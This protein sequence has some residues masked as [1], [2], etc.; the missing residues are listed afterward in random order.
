VADDLGDDVSEPIA[1]RDDPGAV[2]FGGFDM[3]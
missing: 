2:E 1:D 3:Q